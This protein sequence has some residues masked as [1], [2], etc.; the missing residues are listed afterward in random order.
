[1][2]VVS[3][4]E[5]LTLCRS[6]SVA[7]FEV[8]LKEGPADTSGNFSALFVDAFEDPSNFWNVKLD[9]LELVKV[10]RGAAS[11]GSVLLFDRIKIRSGSSAGGEAASRLHSILSPHVKNLA[12][13]LDPNIIPETVMQ[14]D[15][16]YFREITSQVSPKMKELLSVRV[17][18]V[19]AER[20]LMKEE[21]KAENQSIISFDT[22]RALMQEEKE[23]FR[24]LD[25]RSKQEFDGE[26][27][28]YA[29]VKK[30][31]RIDK[32]EHF[33]ISR[34]EGV[35]GCRELEKALEG[36]GIGKLD[37]VVVYCGTGWRASL[38]LVMAQKMGFEGFQVYDGGWYEWSE[39]LM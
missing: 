15:G 13:I 18:T 19:E 29:Y 12:V 32:S 7:I 3:L 39:K 10:K 38:F 25:C 37:R 5:A 31:G 23:N 28:G 11:A 1:M 33:D 8:C 20:D 4:D 27:T 34:F 26:I 30:L 24:L 9:P 6:E 22:F 21:A 35:E 17:H 36:A 14:R 2:V 16:E